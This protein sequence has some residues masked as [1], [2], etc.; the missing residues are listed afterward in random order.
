M[1]YTT[2]DQKQFDLALRS[3]VQDITWNRF[4]QAMVQC[5]GL[6]NVLN[7]KESKKNHEMIFK[8]QELWIRAL[9]LGNDTIEREVIIAQLKKI[10][11]T[12]ASLDPVPLDLVKKV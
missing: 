2:F 4:K 10:T 6:L 5:N 7:G 11:S 1:Q 9:R 12:W 8:I 3:I